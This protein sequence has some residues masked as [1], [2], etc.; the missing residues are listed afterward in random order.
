MKFLTTS[1]LLLVIGPLASSY[2]HSYSGMV[3]SLCTMII[4]YTYAAVKKQGN[5]YFFFFFF[6]SHRTRQASPFSRPMPLAYAPA[7]QARIE[8]RTM[9]C[10]SFILQVCYA[11]SFIFLSLRQLRFLKL[12]PE[13]TFPQQAYPDNHNRPHPD[14]LHRHSRL[15]PSVVGVKG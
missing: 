3:I 10:Q 8:I 9:P 2:Y 14:V 15:Y 4:W 5:S 7:R 13:I 11:R 6:F 12:F 1:F